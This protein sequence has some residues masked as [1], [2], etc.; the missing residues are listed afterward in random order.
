MSLIF[1]NFVI[2]SNVDVIVAGDQYLLILIE[3]QINLIGSITSRC[4]N[5]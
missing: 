5:Y 2:A 1:L 4:V 3:Y